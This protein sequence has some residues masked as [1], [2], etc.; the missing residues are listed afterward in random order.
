MEAYVSNMFLIFFSGQFPFSPQ[1]QSR[2]SLN[3]CAMGG[4]L[5][6][7]F[8]RWEKGVGRGG[9]QSSQNSPSVWFL[10]HQA[11][12]FLWERQQVCIT[13]KMFKNRLVKRVRLSGLQVC[14]CICLGAVT[15]Q[16]QSQSRCS[17]ATA[18]RQ[19]LRG[20]E[21]DDSK[22]TEAPCPAFCSQ[23]PPSAFH[24]GSAR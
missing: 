16:Q 18:K 14:S 17:T 22:P 12:V 10:L 8:R 5:L 19:R 21:A 20:D 4:R 13:R 7:Y 15:G 24:A 9:K 1:R 23:F 3:L 11:L 6:F 2:K